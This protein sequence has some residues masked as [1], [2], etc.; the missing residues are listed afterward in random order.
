MTLCGRPSILVVGNME[1]FR[2]ETKANCTKASSPVRLYK[3]GS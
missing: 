1:H 3:R 2:G